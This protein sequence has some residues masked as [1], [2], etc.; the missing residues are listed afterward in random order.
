MSFVALVAVNCSVLYRSDLHQSG[1]WSKTVATMKMIAPTIRNF[2]VTH[3]YFFKTS[4]LTSII[5]G[6]MF[7]ASLS[8][9]IKNC[10]KPVCNC[11]LKIRP[12][13][14]G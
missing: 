8:C 7:K 6:Y 13:Q 12:V 2:H 11:I 5:C 9:Q 1:I 3:L 10:H 14:T 4:M